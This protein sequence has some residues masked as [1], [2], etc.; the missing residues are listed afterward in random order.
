MEIIVIIHMLSTIISNVF[1]DVFLNYLNDITVSNSNQMSRV[2]GWDPYYQCPSHRPLTAGRAQVSLITLS[3]RIFWHGLMSHRNGM[4][5]S[6][7]LLITPVIFLLSQVKMFAVKNILLGHF[8]LI[9][10]GFSFICKN[11]RVM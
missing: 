7:M 11:E 8:L 10:L 3:G 4:K 9:C 6:L 5:S 2:C 1:I